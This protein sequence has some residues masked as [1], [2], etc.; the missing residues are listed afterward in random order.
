[1]D[2]RRKRIARDLA[3]IAAS[4]AATAHLSGVARGSEWPDGPAGARRDNRADG[5]VA[6]IRMAACQSK[7]CA[8]CGPEAGRCHILIGFAGPAGSLKRWWST[9]AFGESLATPVVLCKCC[10]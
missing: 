5:V 2:R 10:I 6:A 9:T 4:R 3:R 1:M 7:V 8:H